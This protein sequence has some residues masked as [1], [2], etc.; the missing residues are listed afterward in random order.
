MQLCRTFPK[1]DSVPA[2]SPLGMGNK[3]QL[4]KEKQRSMEFKVDSMTLVVI[5]FGVGTAVTGTLQLFMA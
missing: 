5:L 1:L 2:E 4:N 3:A